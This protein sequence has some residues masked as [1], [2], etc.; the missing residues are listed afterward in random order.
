VYPGLAVARA[1][2]SRAQQEGEPLELLYIG[3]RGR[4][5]EAIV[6]REGLAFR[7]IAAGQLRVASPLTFMRNML[8][9]AQGTLQSISIL[10]RFK[11]DAVFATGGYASVPVGVAARLLRRPLVVYLPD[12][13]PGWAVRLLA[14]LATVLTTTSERGRGHLQAAKTRVVGYPVRE[15]FWSIDRIAA[16]A[17]LGVAPDARLLLVTAGSQGAQRINDAIFAAL[18]ELL[19]AGEI[20][21]VTGV[22]GEARANEQRAKLND[23][24]RARYRV[25]GYLEDM[26]AAMIAADLAISRAG[27]S[28]L[29]ELPAANLP[30]ILVPGEYEGWSQAPNAEYLQ[31]EGA[32]VMLRNNELP[33]LAGTALELLRD[34]A[35]L[36]QMRDAMRQLAHPNAARD[37]AAIVWEVAA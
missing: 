12:V 27:A 32:A 19:A 6:P 21:H 22:A 9:L 17:K 26:P 30:A 18:P 10:R 36:A 34:D 20:I 14:R 31:S 8:R 7:P 15:E 23:E 2:R 13:T 29:G 16:R 11:P 33:R 5:D 24:Q 3:V 37:A 35:R 25:R 1:L 28:T 4:V